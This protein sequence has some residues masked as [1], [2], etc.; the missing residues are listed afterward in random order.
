MFNYDLVI[1]LENITAQD[2]MDMYNMKNFKT[3]VEDGK[4]VGFVKEDTNN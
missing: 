4:V 2:C 3:I 1:E